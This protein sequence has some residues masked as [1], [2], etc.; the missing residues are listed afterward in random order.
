M[1]KVK[2]TTV[3]AT[4]GIATKI[5][6]LISSSD[7]KTLLVYSDNKSEGK[8]TAILSIA[9][10][11][12][13]LYQRRVLILDHSNK[14]TDDLEKLLVTQDFDDNFVSK[15]KF[16]G[17][18]F[19]RQSTLDDK[20]ISLEHL[21]EYYDLVLVNTTNYRDETKVSIPTIKYDGALLVRTNKSLGNK[22]GINSK[23]VLDINIPIIGIIF[24]EGKCNE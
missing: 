8:T 1:Q 11:M 14:A 17:V 5:N 4:E 22:M 19:I 7:S 20:S 12:R 10:V 23:N 15:T 13:S 6:Y 3:D 9:P 18:D 16:S 2:T 24:N 21:E